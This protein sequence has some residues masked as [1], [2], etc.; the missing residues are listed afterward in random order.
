MNG[1]GFS[2]DC[3]LSLGPSILYDYHMYARKYITYTIYTIYTDMHITPNADT[4]FPLQRPRAPGEIYH[5]E[6]LVRGLFKGVSVNWIKGPIATWRHLHWLVGINGSGK[7]MGNIFTG[8]FMVFYMF[9]PWN[10]WGFSGKHFP[11]TAAPMTELGRRPW[12][13]YRR[14]FVFISW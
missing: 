9:L 3:S 5:T 8:N 12:P 2:V 11:V 7:K 6:G 1:L 4:Y 13:A 14:W 10:S